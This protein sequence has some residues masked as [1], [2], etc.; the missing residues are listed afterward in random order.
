[1]CESDN[2]SVFRTW[3]QQHG[4]EDRIASLAPY[5]RQPDDPDGYLATNTLL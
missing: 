1:M 5:L 3:L 2:E 4:M